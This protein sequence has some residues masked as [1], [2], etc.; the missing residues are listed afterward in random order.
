M[1]YLLSLFECTCKFCRLLQGLSVFRSYNCCICVSAHYAAV[2][3]QVLVDKFPK[4][5]IIQSKLQSSL[6]DFVLKIG[7][8]LVYTKK[9][10]FFLKTKLSPLFNY[11]FY[12]S[13]I[14]I[15]IDAKMVILLQAYASAS[16]SSGSR[17]F[18]RGFTTFGF[19][20][21]SY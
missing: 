10:N 15:I 8:K 9:K 16:S 3:H 21:K 17:Y 14:Y 11:K 1:A 18:V 13:K 6:H 2:N 20:E 12:L 5:Y 4:N 7:I 19:A